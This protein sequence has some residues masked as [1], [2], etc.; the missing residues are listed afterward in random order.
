MKTI[1]KQVEEK[2]RAEIFGHPGREEQMRINR[3]EEIVLKLA[4][5][6]DNLIMFK[7][8]V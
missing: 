4:E 1:K 2:L 6:I 8:D 5:Q 3:L 7:K